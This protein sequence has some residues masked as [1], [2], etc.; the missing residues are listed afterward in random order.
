MTDFGKS[1]GD[2]LKSVYDPDGDGVVDVSR[3]MGYGTLRPALVSYVADRKLNGARNVAISGNYAYV[4]GHDSDRLVVVNISDPA[5]L[6]IE[7]SITDPVL[8]GA[9]GVAISGNYAYVG[10]EISDRLVVVNISDPA[11]PSIEGSIT[12]P[13]LDGANGVAISGNYAYISAR[14]G[15]TLVVLSL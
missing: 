10:A 15:K 12:D 9:S 14:A 2:M 6:S 11:N 8:S 3:S 7:G 1:A 13:V 5:N 4:T